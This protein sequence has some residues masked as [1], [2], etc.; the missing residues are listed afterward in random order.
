MSLSRYLLEFANEN[1]GKA[2]GAVIGL[3]LGILV[4]TFGVAKTFV[5]LL[6]I[7]LGFIIGKMVDDK[8]SVIDEIRRIFSR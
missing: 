7:L 4:L 6:F 8:V 2:V 1:P 5:I 3:I